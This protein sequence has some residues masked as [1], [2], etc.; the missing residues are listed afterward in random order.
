MKNLF[1]IVFLCCVVS[2]NAMERSITGWDAQLSAKNDK[3]FES[4]VLSDLN[5]SKIDFTNKF[6]LNYCSGSGYNSNL[7]VQIV[8]KDGVVMGIDARK[9]MIEWAKD[10]YKHQTNLSFHQ[11]S[12]DNF[13]P[14]KNSFKFNVATLFNSFDLLGKKL[15]VCKKIYNCLGPQGDFLVNVGP[16]EEP[17]DI[18]VSR[19]MLQS[20]PLMGSLLCSYGL[21]NVF[22]ASYS[23]QQ[24]YKNILEQAGFEIV[25]FVKKERCLVFT[26]KEDFAAIKR[27]IAQSRPI[28]SSIPSWIFEYAFN[29]FIDQFLTKLQKNENG[30]LVYLFN[31]ILI[32]ARKPEK[33]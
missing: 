33:K 28:V 18:Q 8:G 19:E 5:D 27:P 1:C 21:E 13:E 9:N 26:N 16:G 10:M 3:L 24:E 25:S 29:K 4:L 6:V 22:Q 17:L 7:I 14:S 23:T 2:V 11:Y 12:I 31:E 15:E 32:H 30:H 20:V